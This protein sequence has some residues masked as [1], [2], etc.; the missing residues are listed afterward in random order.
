MSNRLERL[1]HAAE[2]LETAFEEVSVIG[3]DDEPFVVATRHTKLFKS[4]DCQHEVVTRRENVRARIVDGKLASGQRDNVDAFAYIVSCRNCHE[5][6]DFERVDPDR[7][8]KPNPSP[9]S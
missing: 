4:Y 8:P 6:F 5:V 9:I 7:V 3:T 1:V 2:G